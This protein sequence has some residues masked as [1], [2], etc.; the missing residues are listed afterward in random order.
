MELKDLRSEIDEIDDQLVKLFTKRMEVSA[1]IAGVKK[2]KSLPIFVP[3]REREKLADVAEKA[4]PDMAIYTRVLY[5]MLFE[6]SRSH[7]NKMNGKISPLY[8]QIVD[9][10]HG[11]CGGVLQRQ[12][13]VPAQSLINGGKYTFK[14]FEVH[15]EGILE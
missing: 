3:A 2:E 1:K 7:Q 9:L 10:F 5:S 11:T 4:G 14:I 15:D 13:T 12:H 8:H 6:L